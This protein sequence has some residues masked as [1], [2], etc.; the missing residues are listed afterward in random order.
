MKIYL[1]LIV[2]LATLG[3]S[4]NLLDYDDAKTNGNG[5]NTD[6]LSADDIDAYLD[7]R[8]RSVGSDDPNIDLKKKLFPDAYEIP[9]A[10]TEIKNNFDFFAFRNKRITEIGTLYKKAIT[11]R[12]MLNIF[13]KEKE[14]RIINE[15][16]Y[17]NIS[18]GIKY[19]KIKKGDVILTVTRNPFTMAASFENTLHHAL[20]CIADPTSDESS[21]FI[22]TDGMVKPEVDLYS[23]THI[24]E[25][26]DFVVVTRA[27]R[28]DEAIIEKIVNFALAQLGKSYNL[29]FSDNL[30]TDR[31]YC[32]QLIWRAY[33]EGGLNIDANDAEVR[34]YGI[35]LASDIYTSPL[36]YIVDYSD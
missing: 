1:W 35:V 12:V 25:T 36:L 28:N 34:D 21:A 5:N 7:A 17:N 9:Y 31:Y 13:R 23:L 15:T 14:F 3:C 30:N 24:K 2:F 26:S 29:D 32:N 8:Y 20:L 16:K 22:T 33:Y 6:C 11:A 10:I 27:Y 4:G 19:D 18:S